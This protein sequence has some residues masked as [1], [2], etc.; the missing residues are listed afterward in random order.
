[1]ACYHNGILLRGWLL[2]TRGELSDR[3]GALHGAIMELPWPNRDTLAFL[4][5]HLQ[6]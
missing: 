5:L 2:E 3:F 4:I 1:M 6:L